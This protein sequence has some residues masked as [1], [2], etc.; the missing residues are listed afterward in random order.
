MLRHKDINIET[1]F[2]LLRVLKKRNKVTRRRIIDGK[3][4][5]Y[6]LKANRVYREAKL[7]PVAVDILREYFH[8]F[9]ISGFSRCFPYTRNTALLHMKQIF[10]R[11][12]CVHALR[13]S[14]ISW[15]VNVKKLPISM[16]ADLLKMD[17]K[18]VSA[19]SHVDAKHELT[20]LYEAA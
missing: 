17:V 18:V 10:G 3:T 11:Q 7:H 9:R 2:F 19:Y 5:T 4:E 13:H 8:N 14:H 12:S 16:V 6:N 1:G 15:L 20:K